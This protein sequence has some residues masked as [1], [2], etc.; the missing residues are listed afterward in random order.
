MINQVF[1][2]KKVSLE[3]T[4]LVKA[5]RSLQLM[6]KTGWNARCLPLSCKSL[7][8]GRFCKTAAL[9]SLAGFA[10]VHPFLPVPL[11]EPDNHILKVWGLDNTFFAQC[12]VV[13]SGM[14]HYFCLSPS[15]TQSMQPRACAAR[16]EFMAGYLLKFSVADTQPLHNA[17]SAQN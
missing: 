10:R 2:P 12:V 17:C 8:V 5:S 4:S 16:V 13:I 15:W 6:A 14:E 11:Q 7:Q 1:F 9:V 3:P